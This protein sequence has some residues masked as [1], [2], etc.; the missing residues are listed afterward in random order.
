M[1]HDPPGDNYELYIDCC[2]LSDVV[3]WRSSNFK[4]KIQHFKLLHVIWRGKSA[5]FIL[6]LAFHKLI[7]GRESSFSELRTS[8]NFLSVLNHLASGLPVYH[9]ILL[10]TPT[11]CWRLWWHR[12][13]FFAVLS[14]F[15]IVLS[16]WNHLCT[17]LSSRHLYA[18]CMPCNLYWT[19]FSILSCLCYCLAK[20]ANKVSWEN[21]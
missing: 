2:H 3:C 4:K 21:I 15:V 16:I 14:F 9:V 10:P 20:F 1:S 17:G 13:N 18:V 7:E 11:K 19:S 6:M 12:V 8:L 5:V